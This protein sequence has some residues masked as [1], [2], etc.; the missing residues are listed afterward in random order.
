M[1]LLA[2][3]DE[4]ERVHDS[5]AAAVWQLPPTRGPSAASR[6]VDLVLA[7]LQASTA[8]VLVCDDH[9]QADGELPGTWE[10]PA[11]GQWLLPD[12]PLDLGELLDWLCA[13]SWQL[14]GF[15]E[16]GPQA[17]PSL[18]LFGQLDDSVGALCKLGSAWA[19]DVFHDDQPWLVFVAAG[20]VA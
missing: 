6:R 11:E 12:V 17:L 5:A 2:R 19:L 4:G 13:G 10:S 7:L 3:L 9:P 16:T 8:A 18:D 15:A 1:D 20:V 14:V